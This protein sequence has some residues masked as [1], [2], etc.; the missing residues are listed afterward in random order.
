[1]VIFYSFFSVLHLLQFIIFPVLDQLG[2]DASIQE[3]PVHQVHITWTAEHG[4]NRYKSNFPL[5]T[6]LKMPGL[7]FFFFFF[8]IN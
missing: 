1:M 8:Y 2:G 5:F 4:M 6:Q 3:Q 7:F